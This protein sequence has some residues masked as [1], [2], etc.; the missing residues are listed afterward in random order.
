MTK[1]TKVLILLLTVVLVALAIALSINTYT[2]DGVE[3][4]VGVSL[5]NQSSIGDY[6]LYTELLEGAGEDI[7]MLCMDAA[8][9]P[10]KQREDINFLYEQG[11]DVLVVTPTTS[12]RS[13][14][15][16]AID[17]PVIVLDHEQGS[18]AVDC[19][20]IIDSKE[21]GRLAGEWI[22]N[23]APDS[24]VFEIQ[25]NPSLLC[26]NNIKEGLRQS[27]IPSDIIVGNE[28]YDVAYKEILT[29]STLEDEPDVMFAHNSE[30]AHAALSA[31]EDV[32]IVGIMIDNYP[33]NDELRRDLHAVISYP[34]GAKQ[35][36]DV[37]NLIKQ[38]EPYES[39]YSIKPMMIKG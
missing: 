26:T 17:I 21:A 2:H 25:D 38:D 22:Q 3:L 12:S 14:L 6:Q 34:S 39:L 16:S 1:T 27:I 24:K 18:T 36:L 37:L 19:H 29:L 30:L 23:N 28:D 9:D 4:V 20:I 7:S 31:T 33:G 35:I 8:S 32:P 15:L 10:A 5:A 11:V 13:L